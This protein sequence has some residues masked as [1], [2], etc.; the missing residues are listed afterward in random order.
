MLKSSEI[1]KL[2]KQGKPLPPKADHF[3]KFY[4]Y[5]LDI[6]IER[7]RQNKLS[8]ED[9]KIYYRGYKEIY[10]QLVLWYEILKKH[11]E[12]EKLL[13]QADLCIDGCEKCRKVARLLDGRE[14]I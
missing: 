11:R 10:E 4:Y 14:K 5:A 13:G 2:I 7:Y 9:F 8:R 12:I 1:E 6:C 3:E